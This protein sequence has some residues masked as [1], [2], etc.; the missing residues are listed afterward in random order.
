VRVGL[1]LLELAREGHARTIFVVG[2]GKNVGK[3]TA[4]LAIYEAACR[5]GL[6]VG[7]ASIGP[8]PRLRLRPNTL[9][10]TARPLLVPSPAVEI[11]E[12]SQLE[13]S[14]GPLLYARTAHDGLYDLAGPSS[15]SGLREAVEA[16]SAHSDIVLIDGAIDRIAT[17]ASADGAI[18]VSCGA[19]AAKT[20]AEALSDVATLTARLR[21]PAF[22][23][24]DAV[25]E[26]DGALTA[27]MAADF[28]A[29]AEARQIVVGDSTQIV[30]HG[31]S[32]AEALARLRIRCRR[33]FDVIATTVCAVAPERSFDPAA[34][35]TAVAGATNLPSFDV[36]AGR[37]AA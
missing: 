11:L 28:I 12:I 3:T 27:T 18:V 20:E 25:L 37:E 21:V 7:L 8:K 23:P 6:R 36:F 15:A 29:A 10:V 2:T 9:F 32:L 17:L 16:I 24:D 30:M 14:S 1:R 34:F 33:S 31:R 13:S 35:L 19:A 26:V 22:D 5:S 4:L